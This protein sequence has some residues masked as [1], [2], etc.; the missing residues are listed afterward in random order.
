MRLTQRYPF[1]AS[2][3][4]HSGELSAEENCRVFGKCNNPY[5]HGHNYFVEVSVSGEPDPET[6]LLLDRARFDAWVEK[7]ILTRVAHRNL[8]E[9][10]VEFQSLVPTTE[11]L[12]LVFTE[13]L[14]RSWPSHFAAEP[15]LRF[16]RVRIYET[17]NN[18]F[19]MEAH[20]IQ[21]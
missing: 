16:D 15:K 11:N 9:E 3:R 4:L 12:A 6:G 13:A 14:S 2:H 5:G 1:S 18:L 8:N 19:E 17:R 20:E 21:Q 7:E 10:M